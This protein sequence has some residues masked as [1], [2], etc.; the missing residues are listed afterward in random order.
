MRITFRKILSFTRY[1]LFFSFV[2]IIAMF[3]AR[4]SNYIFVSEIKAFQ[5]TLTEQRETTDAIEQTAITDR[6]VTKN[7]E[8]ARHKV[9]AN[10]PVLKLFYIDEFRNI[11]LIR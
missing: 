2:L 1:I 8:I 5:Y 3:I 10:I 9:L 7:K 11:E 6:I 4:V